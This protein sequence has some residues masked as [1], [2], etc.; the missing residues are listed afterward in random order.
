MS[1]TMDRS[2]NDNVDLAVA[3]AEIVM[4]EDSESEIVSEHNSEEGK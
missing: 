4:N 3:E 1:A 2:L